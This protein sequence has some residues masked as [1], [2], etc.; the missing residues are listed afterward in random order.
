MA[1][2]RKLKHLEMI[3]GVINRLAANLRDRRPSLRARLQQ[4]QARRLAMRSA[5]RKHKQQIAFN[6]FQ[7]STGSCSCLGSVR[8][9]A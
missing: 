5:S 6:S 9:S 4:E 1:D 3:Q 7:P 8:L 2:E